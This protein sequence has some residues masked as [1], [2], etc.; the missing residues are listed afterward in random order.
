MQDSSRQLLRLRPRMVPHFP[1]VVFIITTMLL[2]IGA[3]NGQ[4]NLLFWVFGLAI[5]ALLG[6][7]V[8]GAWTIAS[9]RV[10]RDPLPPCHAGE[11]TRITYRITNLSRWIPAF[12]VSVSELPDRPRAV[13]PPRPAP[14]WPARFTR[15]IAF[16]EYIPRGGTVTVHAE[17][18][19]ISR[20][21]AIFDAVEVWT[22][23]PFG[24]SRKTMLQ[25]RTQAALVRPRLFPL[26]PEFLAMLAPAI[27]GISATVTSRTGSGDEFHSLREFAEGDA[28]RSIAW[29]RSAT[30]DRLLVRQTARP[31]HRKLWIGIAGLD[32]VPADHAE[33]AIDAAASLASGA[34][35]LGYAVGL[36]ASEKSPSTA[37]RQG[38][39]ALH[40]ILDLLAAINPAEHSPPGPISGHRA[41]VVI[42]DPLRRPWP[43]SGTVAAPAEVI[44]DQP[45]PIAVA[46][47]TERFRSLLGRIG[48]RFVSQ[49]PTAASSA[50]GPP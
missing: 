3:I 44:G 1:A 12:A 7:G 23:F 6:S 35:A 28:P 46:T 22:S 32:G 26:R 2:P 36:L 41:A 33:H 29:K 50:G 30:S 38:H 15:G 45:G 16:A 27:E 49:G 10:E 17:V 9:I 8:M 43:G 18:A 24:L 42:I 37:A 14:T 5:A 48:R 47:G 11:V 25:A 19:A 21:E 39:R 20:G 40:E 13:R 31:V 4:N 34:T